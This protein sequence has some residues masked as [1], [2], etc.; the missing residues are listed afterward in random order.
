[1]LLYRVKGAEYVV[2]SYLFHCTMG[3][4]FFFDDEIVLTRIYIYAVVKALLQ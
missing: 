2:V 1:M 3:L 4:M